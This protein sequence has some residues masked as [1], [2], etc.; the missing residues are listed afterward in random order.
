[1]PLSLDTFNIDLTVSDGPGDGGKNDEEIPIYNLLGR[2]VFITI[3]K[4]KPFPVD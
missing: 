4:I 3:V 1:M 2:A